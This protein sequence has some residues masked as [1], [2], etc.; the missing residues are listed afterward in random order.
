MYVCP[1][2]AYA[3]PI[4]SRTPCV[5]L[6]FS[7]SYEIKHIYRHTEKEEKKTEDYENPRS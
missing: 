5:L 3:N 7:V 6:G 4:S 1:R 2:E